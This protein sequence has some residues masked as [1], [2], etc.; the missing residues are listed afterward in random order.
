MSQCKFMVLDGLTL[1]N[2]DILSVDGQLEGS[3]L[4]KIDRASTAFGKR[5]LREWLAAPLCDLK[6]IRKR[7]VWFRCF[8]FFFF[9]FFALVV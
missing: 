4:A 1:N 5:L 7:Q 2:L 3:L 6:A 8:F 9:F